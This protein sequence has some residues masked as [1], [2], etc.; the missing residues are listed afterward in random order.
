VRP[1]SGREGSLISLQSFTADRSSEDIAFAFSFVCIS[2]LSLE[3]GMRKFAFASASAP[4]LSPYASRSVLRCSTFTIHGHTSTL[5]L[6]PLIAAHHAHATVVP[7]APPP[8]SQE[9]RDD[10]QRDGPWTADGCSETELGGC[11]HILQWR[12]MPARRHRGSQMRLP[13]DGSK[14][15]LIDLTNPSPMWFC[16]RPRMLE[17]TTPS[18]A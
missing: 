18:V 13:V 10:P 6:H 14:A 5:I 3:R 17:S 2:A 1:G 7:R 12:K 16:L 8:C 11:R 9:R 4:F 15:L